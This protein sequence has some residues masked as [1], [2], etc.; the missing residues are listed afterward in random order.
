MSKTFHVSAQVTISLYCRVE[1][2]SEAEALAIAAERAVIIDAHPR[3]YWDIPEQEGGAENLRAE[4]VN[5]G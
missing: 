1:A 5:D 4:E 3:S 2:D